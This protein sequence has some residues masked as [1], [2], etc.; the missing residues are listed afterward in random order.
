MFFLFFLFLFFFS[1][2]FFL[3]LFLLSF[4]LLSLS[5]LTKKKNSETDKEKREVGYQFIEGDIEWTVKN[6][7]FLPSLSVIAGIAAGF[8]GI[9]G[10]MVLFLFSFSFLFS[11]FL[12]IFFFFY[13]LFF[14]FLLSSS[15]SPF[16]LFFL[17]L[18]RK[19]KRAINVVNG[20]DI[21]CIDR[22][23]FFYDSFY[24]FFNN[25]AIFNP[26]FVIFLFFSFSFNFPTLNDFYLERVEKIESNLISF[27]KLS[28]KIKKNKNRKNSNLLRPLLLH[29]WNLRSNSRKHVGVIHRQKIQKTILCRFSLGFLYCL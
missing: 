27:K 15:L 9:G 12:L 4:S 2:F 11:F 28:Q 5:F 8:L 13:F 23:E 18:R 17:S 6:L 21:T 7:F 10:G 14:L 22:H 19:G 20:D 29:N 25:N 16:S 1:S 3:L 26:W 24:F